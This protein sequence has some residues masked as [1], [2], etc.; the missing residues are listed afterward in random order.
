MP[1]IEHTLIGRRMNI[2]TGYGGRYKLED[3]HEVPHCV[4]STKP[5]EIS[6][7]LRLAAWIVSGRLFFN[8]QNPDIGLIQPLTA[9]HI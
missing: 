7:Q 4:V 3:V 8:D 5:K 2:R 6:C 9:I 1:E